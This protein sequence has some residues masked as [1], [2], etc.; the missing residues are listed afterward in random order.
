MKLHHLTL[1]EI[2]FIQKLRDNLT[3]ENY[4]RISLAVKFFWGFWGLVFLYE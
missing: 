2:E 1:N 3:D 4:N